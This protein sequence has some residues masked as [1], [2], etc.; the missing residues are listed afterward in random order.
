MLIPIQKTYKKLKLKTKLQH[1]PCSFIF[2]PSSEKS[3][4]VAVQRGLAS[5]RR[6]FNPI[7]PLTG[8]LTLVKA[9]IF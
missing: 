2:T 7:T 5:G 8:F 9:C 4:V 3:S 1:Q 6:G